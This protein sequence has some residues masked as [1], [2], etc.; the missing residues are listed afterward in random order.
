[1]SHTYANNAQVVT[2]SSNCIGILGTNL[3]GGY[4][5][6][7]GLYG[8]G[9]DNILS[10]NTVL[11][12]GTFLQVTP[13]ESDLF[14]ALREAAPNFGIVASV[15]M[16]SYPVPASQSTTWTGILLF[17][18]DKIESIV[19]AIQDLVLGS[20]MNI[21]LYYGTSGAP[22]FNPTVVVTPFYYGSETNGKTAFVSILALQPFTDTTAK[23][24]YNQWNAGG[25][26]F[27]VKGGR[28]PTY[29]GGAPDYRP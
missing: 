26:S 25:D 5:N 21:Y 22:S 18:E 28:K 6:L 27:C 2:G 20:Y 4:G 9:V 8:L 14:W 29:S 13:K 19:Q 1:M 7:G 17:T 10:L 12:N 23:N 16:K 15:I 3:G 11:A 24:P